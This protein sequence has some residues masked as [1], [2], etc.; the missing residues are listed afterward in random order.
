MVQMSL[1]DVTRWLFPQPQ[2]HN[3]GSQGLIGGSDIVSGAPTVIVQEQQ[4]VMP[5]RKRAEQVQKQN[6]HLNYLFAKHHI[7]LANYPMFESGR[8]NSP[9]GGRIYTKFGPM[10]NSLEDGTWTP[11]RN[12]GERWGDERDP[13]W[14]TPEY[15]M[16]HLDVMPSWYINGEPPTPEAIHYSRGRAPKIQFGEETANAELATNVSV[17]YTTTNP[18]ANAGEALTRLL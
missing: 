13:D 17:S 3:S 2:S 12:L 11:N 7:N 14:G 9:F 16:T 1:K 10:V 6:Q 15:D 18:N 8:I 4:W 5:A